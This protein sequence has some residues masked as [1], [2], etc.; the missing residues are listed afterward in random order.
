MRRVIAVLLLAL[1]GSTALAGCT[2]AGGSGGGSISAG[3]ASDSGAAAASTGSA[4]QPTEDRSVVMTGS[5]LLVSAHPSDAAQRVAA[6]AGSAGG[7]IARRDEDLCGR[8]GATLVLRIPANDFD[9]VLA[10]I[11]H[12]GRARD[13]TTTATD[14]T[15]Q[16]TDY[17]TRIANLRTSIARLRQLL[18]RAASSSALVDIEGSLTEREGSLEQLLAQQRTLADQVADATLTVRIVA[19]SAVPR[20]QPATFLSG[21]VAGAGALASTAAGIAVAVGVLLPWAAVL[22]VLLA[23]GLVVRRPVRRR[24]ATAA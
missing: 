11:E 7:S 12:A 1:L 21:L 17:A 19:P 14:V 24:R 10:Q 15:G 9:R 6:L 2:A 22:G 3:S 13:V 16:V 8:T 5:L 4:K 18:A 23:I 20:P